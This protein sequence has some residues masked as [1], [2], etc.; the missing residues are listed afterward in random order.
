VKSF[1]NKYVEFVRQPD[2]GRML[3]A[4]LLS[5]MPVGMLAFGMLMFLREN[6]GNFAHAGSAVGIEFVA[7]AIAAPIVGRIVDRQGPRRVLYVTGAVQP[8]ALV[9]MLVAAKMA[10]GFSAVVVFAVIAG[11]FSTPITTLTRAMWRYRFE[12]EEDRRTAFALDSVAIEINFTLGPSIMAAVLA[13]AGATAAFVVVIVAVVLAFFVFLGSPALR[14]L[15]R[16]ENAGERHLLG[17][18]TDRRLQLIFLATFGLT[19]SLGLLEVGY[20]A[21]G[22]AAAA[23]A[24]GGLLLG[25]NSIGSAVGGALYGGLHFRMPIERQFASAVGLMAVGLLLHAVAMP[26]TG[27][28]FVVAFLAG[29]LIAPSIASQSVLVSRLAPAQYVTEAFT[30]GSMCIISGIGAG[31]AL[32]GVLVE[33]LGLMPVF[34]VSGAIAGATALLALSIHAPHPEAAAARA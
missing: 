16:V 26:V 29:M 22:I 23:P 15:K 8:L 4:A 3:L 33:S 13:L 20:P 10:L 5:R 24:M 34:A 19:M 28:F 9:G 2:V 7:A 11:A 17:P 32:G 18:L 25:V 12:R 27:A 21:Y 14:Y 31:I 30:W 1:L 6:L